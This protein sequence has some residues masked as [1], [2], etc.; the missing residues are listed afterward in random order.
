MNSRI[1][2]LLNARKRK[3]TLELND[4]EAELKLYITPPPSPSGGDMSQMVSLLSAFS[5]VPADESKATGHGRAF[6]VAV[7]AT[8]AACREKVYCIVTTVLAGLS[9]AM[10]TKK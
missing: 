8:V 2:E 4:V 9:Q 5:L 1:R 3:L 7:V 10:R 6:A